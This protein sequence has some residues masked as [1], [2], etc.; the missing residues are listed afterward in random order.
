VEYASNKENIFDIGFQ[1]LFNTMGSM[2]VDSMVVGSKRVAGRTVLGMELD[3]IVELGQKL[4]R[5]LAGQLGLVLKLILK[6]INKMYVISLIK[7]IERFKS[8][9][10]SV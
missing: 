9:L 7:F 3:R 1:E 8:Y 10:A 4:G 6:E 2:V 5:K